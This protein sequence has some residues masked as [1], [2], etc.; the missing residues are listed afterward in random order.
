[1]KKIILFLFAVLCSTSMFAW[2]VASNF[3]SGTDTWADS[4]EISGDSFTSDDLLAGKVYQFKVKEGD[5]E[6]WKGFENLD[7][8]TVVCG[9]YG[10]DA[11]DCNICFVLKEAGKVTITYKSGKIAVSGNFDD[12]GV[13]L[14][15]AN[16]TETTPNFDLSADRLTA[17]YTIKADTLKANRDLKVQLQMPGGFLSDD[18]PGLSRTRTET[19][20]FYTNK[21]IMSINLDEVGDYKLTYNFAT[22]KL[23]IVYPELV[24][25]YF[26]YGNFGADDN[27]NEYEMTEASGVWAGSV[28]PAAAK[29]QYKFKLRTRTGFY[30]YSYFGA[31]YPNS[32]MK[33]DDCTDWN[34]T[35]DGHDIILIPAN[36]GAYTFQFTP[37]TKKFSAVYPVAAAI[38]NTEVAEK[39]VK[40]MENGQLVIIKNGVR[41]NAQGPMVR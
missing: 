35:D 8:S 32:E 11:G 12:F 14:L 24:T 22:R 26:V 27:W 31:Q 28:T 39:V 15:I 34:L 19:N 9:I 29:T 3:A 33:S 30:D 17:T 5:P 13:K 40:T 25:R 37:G 6:V 16:Y 23:S 4:P 20:A 18:H 41:Y 38:D 10:N 1:M 21:G 7:P 36:T 2:K